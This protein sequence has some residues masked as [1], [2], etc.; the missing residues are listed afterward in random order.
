MNILL[1]T[2]SYSS[3]GEGSAAAGVFVH[4]FA[5]ALTR[6]GTRVQVIAPAFERHSET[7]GDLSVKRFPVP[8]LPLSTLNPLSPLDWIPI[9]K[10]L[11]AGRHAVLEACEESPP[12][13]ILALWALP[14]GAWARQ[15]AHRFSVPYGIW[16]LG[17][18][19]WGLGRLSIIRA[20]LASVLREATVCFADGIALGMAVQE[21]SGRACTFLPSSRDFGPPPKRILNAAPPYRLVFL[22]R[23]HPNK[24]PDLVLGA[25]ATLTQHEWTKIEAVRICGG[26]PL[27]AKLQAGVAALV[28]A[29]RPVELGGYLNHPAA[30]ALFDWADYVVIPSRIE[31]IPV[32]FSDAMQAQRPVIATPVGDIPKLIT[33]HACGILAHEVSAAG[34]ADAIR[35]ALE[36]GPGQF[37]QG[38]GSAAAAFNVQVAAD[39]FLAQLRARIKT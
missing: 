5:L 19:I 1:V 34:I 10:T 7:D 26:G 2:S 17:S 21:I 16:A 25:L 35:H 11:A 3:S 20:Q 12:D 14:C 18:D 36:T 32:V 33:K 22:G 27:A 37:R 15:A 23:W 6:R 38:L 39:D 30:Y 8:R 28:A 4:D 13:L 9:V 29:G 24:G 31:S